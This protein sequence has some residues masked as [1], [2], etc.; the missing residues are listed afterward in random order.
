MNKGIV[1]AG[2]GA[3]GKTILGKKYVNIID[4]E[5]SYYKWDN[6]GFEN[7]SSE[8]LKGIVRPVNKDWPSNYHKAIVE[9]RKKYDVVLTSMHD[10]VL[11]FLEKNN[12]EYYLALPTID[13]IE[14]IKKRCYERGN[15]KKFVDILIA[16]LYD[17]YK[18]L[19]DYHPKKVL[20]LKKD[21]YLENVLI[22]SG[23]L[24]K[25]GDLNE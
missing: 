18:R 25:V 12:I 16:T 3:I 13:S 7:L 17:F 23:I 24:D 19:K 9:Y 6:T 8:E 21:E 4:L 10:H 1:V 2:F 5:S 14:V 11:R 20:L 15:N 22:K